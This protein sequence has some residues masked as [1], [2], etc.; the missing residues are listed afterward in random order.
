MNSKFPSAMLPI[1][2]NTP[3]ASSLLGRT[4]VGISSRLV[5]MEATSLLDVFVCY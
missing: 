2:F 3:L 4:V 1:I 5:E